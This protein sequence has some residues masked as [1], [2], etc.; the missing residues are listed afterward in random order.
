MAAT[1][2]KKITQKSGTVITVSYQNGHANDTNSQALAPVAG[3]VT[4]LANSKGPLT[5]T[6][7]D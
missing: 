4:N 2:T 1:I 6:Y 7:V 3:P 5:I